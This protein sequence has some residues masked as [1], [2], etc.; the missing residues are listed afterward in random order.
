MAGIRTITKVRETAQ[1]VFSVMDGFINFE[2][3]ESLVKVAFNGDKGEFVR[4][5]EVEVYGKTVIFTPLKSYRVLLEPIET[6]SSTPIVVRLKPI[7]KEE[8]K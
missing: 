5:Y 4:E 6:V 8:V 3:N 2:A 7:V 1:N